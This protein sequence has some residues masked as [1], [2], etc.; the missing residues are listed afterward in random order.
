MEDDL[1]KSEKSNLKDEEYINLLS[2]LKFAFRNLRKFL[3]I[4]LRIN[5]GLDIPGAINS[6]KRDIVFQGHSIWILIA[7]IFIASIGLNANSTAVV[8]G[9]MLISPLMGPILGVGLSVG[10]NDWKTLK[11]SLRFFLIT[12]IV[13]IITS[14]V[15]FLITPLKE[16]SSEL[17]SRT[18]PT[19]LDVLIALFGGVAGIVAASQKEKSNVIPGVAIATALMPPLCT[20][21]YGLATAQFNYF[22]GALYLFFINSVFISLATLIFV[23]YLKF[24]KAKFINS[25]REKK[26]KRYIL[27][28]IILVILPSTKIFFDVIKETRFN[29]RAT[30]FLDENMN[31]SN[32]DVYSKSIKYNDTL[33]VI[34]VYVIGQDLTDAQIMDLTDKLTQYGLI[35]S[36]GPG[37]KVTDST[38]L[39]VHQAREMNIDSINAKFSTMSNKLENSVRVGILED[40][41]KKKEELLNTKNARIEFLENQMINIKK[42]TVPLKKLKL[43]LAVQYPRIERF[44]YAKSIEIDTCGV[45][46]TIP[47]F[48]IDWNKRI[49]KNE[50]KKKTEVLKNWLKVRLSLDTLRLVEY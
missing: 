42:D 11:K 2:S 50:K 17:L 6:I 12:M 23:R 47:V 45:Y 27:F 35:G 38:T 10:T 18:K 40:I 34:D 7:S 36:K 1:K 14:A 21:G 9:A 30:A 24:P 5:D 37:I 3:Y 20:A 8:I 48:L 28:F 46:D 43:E 41:Y 19:F 49:Y 29:S 26:V 22:F 15:Y 25:E 13:S 44:A 32:T 4:T 39:S 31:F 16:V 33:S